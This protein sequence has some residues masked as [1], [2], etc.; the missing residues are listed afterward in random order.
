MTGPAEGRPY[1]QY[2]G[3]RYENRNYH[4]R[5]D[6]SGIG[7]LIA[8]VFIM[9]IG[10]AALTGFVAFWTYFWPILLVLLGLWVIILG[11]RRNRRYRQPSPP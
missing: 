8:G 2:S 7:L 5:R 3:R 6:G 9:L 1:N 10:I 4:R 11:L